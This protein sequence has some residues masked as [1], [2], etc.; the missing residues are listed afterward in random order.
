M[1]SSK[2][3]LRAGVGEKMSVR[4]LQKINKNVLTLIRY[5]TGSSGICSDSQVETESTRKNALKL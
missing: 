5:D 2:V 1:R 3:R 4:V